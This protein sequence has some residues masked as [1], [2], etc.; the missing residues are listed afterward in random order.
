MKLKRRIGIGLAVAAATYC[1]LAYIFMWPPIFV[2]RTDTDAD[3]CA[4]NLRQI[5]A[6][7]NQFALEQH[8]H[9]GDPVSLEDIT[10]Y[11]KLNSRGK[12]PGC[13][14]GG[15]YSAMI[16]GVE[17]TCSLGTNPTVKVHGYGLTW[18]YSHDSGSRHRAQ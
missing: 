4:N 2:Y 8:K 7:I 1:V 13:P 14:A 16:V 18:H 11:I 6:A 12:I 9:T 15:I 3:P 10:P 17:P 5:D